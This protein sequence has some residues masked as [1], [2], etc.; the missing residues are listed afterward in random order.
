MVMVLRIVVFLALASAPAFAQHHH[1]M[2]TP[3]E[4]VPRDVFGAGV[5]LV[6]AT[7][8]T[9]AYGGNYQGV[10]P[11]V[12]WSRP[13]Y[14]AALT[15]GYYRLEENGAKVYG[16]GDLSLHGQATLAGDSHASAGI[17]AGV[18]APIGDGRRGTG[19]GHVMVMP[20]LFGTYAL[21]RT[22]F[23]ATAGYSRALGGDA[24]HDHGPWPLVEP[25][26]M[27][28]ISW[29]AGGDVHATRDV[30]I[31][32]RF[33]GG[34]PVGAP[35]DTRVVGAAR[36]GWRAGRVDSAAEIQA[37]LAGDPFNVRGVVSTALSF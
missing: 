31:G 28:E 23:M 8:E 7:Y 27:S 20:A 30:R 11:S 14:A 21:E 5:A 13:R 16:F 4:E 22:S 33:S 9:M 10:L 19:M 17:V 2:E 24:E 26:L 35:G 36:I 32:A 29:S 1:G 34:I 25:M 12:R 3:S 6:A 15:A 37:G 18:T